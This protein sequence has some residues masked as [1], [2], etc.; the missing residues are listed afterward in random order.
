MMAFVSTRSK[1]INIPFKSFKERLYDSIISKSNRFVNCA[2]RQQDCKI[3]ENKHGN[4]PF[5]KTRVSNLVAE[6]E[7]N[8]KCMA[9]SLPI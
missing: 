1:E 9:L 7:R 3:Y 5:L 8:Y 6:L 2:K 4:R